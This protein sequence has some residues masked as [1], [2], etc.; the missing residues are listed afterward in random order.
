MTY[1]PLTDAQRGWLDKA[2]A[3]ATDVLAPAAAE[4]DRTGTFPRAQLDALRDA[5]FMGLRADID[6]GGVGEGLLTTCLVT[7]ALAKACP[8]TALIYKMHLES[9]EMVSRA[10]TAEQAAD[11][12]PKLASGEW[13]STVAGSE[14][15]HQGGAWAGAQKASVEKVDG[16]YQVAGIQKSFVT[17]AGE[18]DSYFFMCSLPQD[19]GRATQLMFQI[20][21]DD[22]DWSIDE[23]WDGLGMRGNN[24][25]PMTFNGFIPDGRLLNPDNQR[26]DFFPVVL[27]TYAA[28]YLGIAAGCYDRLHAHIA[29]AT[30]AD[31]RRMGEVETIM[32][33]VVKAKV[34]IERSRALLYAT[35]AAFDEGRERGARP[36]LEAKV[37]C[38]EVGTFVT[39]EAMTLGGGAAFAKRLPFERYFRDAR[40]GMVM[41]LAHD[42]AVLNIGR[43]I[44]PK[45]KKDKG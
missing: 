4:T 26:V 3:I 6:H 17:A 37:A 42:I 38:D 14:A 5:G 12:V 39:A 22:L 28:T 29:G 31:G 16:G 13:L 36:F 8:S 45:P 44:F 11:V 43:S 18:A 23:P 2:E 1:F 20:H 27:G 33:R 32:S 34:E 41:G 40:A 24:S 21:R 35:C 19:D 10:P 30:L 15:G 25:S 9:A 7:E